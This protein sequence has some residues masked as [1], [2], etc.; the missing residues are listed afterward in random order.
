MY[1]F[2]IKRFNPL[3]FGR[4]ERYEDDITQVK[5]KPPIEQLE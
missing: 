2:G 1:Y 3:I 4:R 5:P